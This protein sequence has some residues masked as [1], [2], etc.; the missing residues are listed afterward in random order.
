MKKI[1]PLLWV[2]VC[3]VFVSVPVHAK[4]PSAK[5]LGK[6]IPDYIQFTTLDGD[7][8]D[9][10]TNKGN[11]IIAYWASWC[12][13]CIKELQVFDVINDDLKQAGITLVLV[14]ADRKSKIAV[15]KAFKKWGIKNL[16]TY[17]G[18]MYDAFKAFDST[19]LPIVVSVKDGKIADIVNLNTH[20]WDVV[21]SLQYFKQVL[22]LLND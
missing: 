15:P 18:N 7:P 4:A 17:K 10:I 19:G 22:G 12:I 8:V 14:N 3:M 16:T 11:Y 21:G 6:P 13:P 2:F 1:L 5:L 20:K 9:V